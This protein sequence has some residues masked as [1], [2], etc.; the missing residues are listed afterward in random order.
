MRNYAQSI[1]SAKQPKSAMQSDFKTALEREITHIGTQNG[2]SEDKAFLIWFLTR[3][4]ELDEDVALEAI[5]VEGANDKGIDFFLVDDEEG[6]VFIGQGKSSPTLTYAAKEK[7]V[8]NLESSLNW[9]AS[10]EALAREGKADL[11]QAATDFLQAQQDG[12]GVELL[13]VYAGP[14]SVNIE[15]KIAVYNQNGDNITRRRSFRHYYLE[16]LKDLWD[17]IEG[18]RRRIK[19][20]TLKVAGAFETNGKF[21]TALVATVPCSEL[22]RLYNAHKDRLFDRN[23]RLFLGSRKGSVNAGLAETIKSEKDRGNFWAYNNGVAIICDKYQ[24]KAD[25]VLLTNFSIVNGCQTAVS[26][27][28][29]DG[30]SPDLAVLVRCIAA[31][32]EIL[33][34]VIRFTN[35]QN[36]IRTWDIASQE[37]TQRR[38]KNEFGALK[39]PWIYQTRRGDRPD[40][41]LKKFRERG[42]LRLIRIDHAGQMMAAFRGK[43]VLA[44]K[45]KAFI[46]SRNHDEVFP[47]DVKVTE[48]LFAW[49]CGELA[50]EAV[51]QQTKKGEANARVL[52]KGGTLFSLAV[53]AEV[54]KCRNGA[55]YLSSLKEEVVNSNR[56]RERLNKYANYAVLAY[57]SAFHDEAEVQ[58][59]ELSTL[60]RQKEFFDKVLQ[61]VV[62]QIE[63]ESLNASWIDGA[64]PKFA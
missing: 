12:Y 61:R 11:A 33:D 57:L 6:R 21:G 23:V 32:S 25:E 51:R 19:S 1:S 58:K 31:T 34:N 59:Q 36:P 41:N 44:Y 15:K 14:K 20:D 17:E 63:R 62:R 16:L 24:H 26:L 45:H 3:I 53:M 22:V 60:V 4:L 18:G 40:G 48:V 37:K 2:L 39:K 55:T 30:I 5:S 54:L 13:Y 42:K 27:A 56:L 10:P 46:F 52:K 29:N 49:I 7:D 38:L 47:P 9:L 8:S 43:P 64:L 35:S 28:E 50:K